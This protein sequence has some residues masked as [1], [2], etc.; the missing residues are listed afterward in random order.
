MFCSAYEL[1]SHHLTLDHRL[2][3]TLHL[4]DCREA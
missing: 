1:W 2:G 4:K 3:I